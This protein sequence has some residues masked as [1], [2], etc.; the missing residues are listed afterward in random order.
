MSASTRSRRKPSVNLAGQR[1]RLDPKTFAK[2][3]RRAAYSGLSIHEEARKAFFQGL[4][5]A[6]LY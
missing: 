1:V 6:G 2:L 4:V 3:R 5:L